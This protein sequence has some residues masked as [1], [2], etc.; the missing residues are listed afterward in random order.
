MAALNVDGGYL[1]HRAKLSSSMLPQL[2]DVPGVLEQLGLR[3]HLRHHSEGYLINIAIRSVVVDIDH[4]GSVDVSIEANVL[5]MCFPIC[6]HFTSCVIRIECCVVVLTFVV[7][8]KNLL[9]SLDILYV[10][11]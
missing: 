11:V 5:H 10:N 6:G 1:H 3:A 9:P 7:R 2:I 8:P 4:I